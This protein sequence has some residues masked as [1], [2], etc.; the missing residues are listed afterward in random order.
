MLAAAVRAASDA[1]QAVTAASAEVCAAAAAGSSVAAAATR[2]KAAAAALSASAD[3]LV[4]A[5][6]A[7]PPS[8][9]VICHDRP[10]A[11]RFGECGHCDCCK[12]CAGR[13]AEQENA[14]CPTCHGDI[15]KVHAQRAE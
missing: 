2:L 13:L 4:A 9:C 3:A 10:V 8:I 1:A 12:T 11:V 14:K 7:A 15:S 6:A 5:A